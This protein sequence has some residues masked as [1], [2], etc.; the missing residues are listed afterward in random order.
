MVVF[1][2]A[3]INLGLSVTSRRPDGYHNLETLFYP[4]GWRDVLEIV[5][6]ADPLLKKGSCRFH[7]VGLDM[8]CAADDNLVVKA[9]RLLNSRY[10]LPA[11]DI[12]LWKVIPFKAGLGGG[13]SDAA[14][15]LTLLNELAGLN[16]PLDEL[17]E[18]AAQIGADCP[19]FIRN[20]PVMARGIG[21]EFSPVDV[22]LK[23]YHICIVKPQ[24]EVSTKEAYGGIVPCEPACSVADIVTNHPVGEWRGVLKNDF[25][26]PVFKL[27]PEIEQIKN[28]LYSHGA[29]YASMTGSGS[30]V[31]ALFTGAVDLRNHFADCDVWAES[32]NIRRA[33]RDSGN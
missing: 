13:S 2:N 8:E 31:F 15:A 20:R 29:V 6:S 22:S 23:N 7:S 19:F 5:P 17:E 12:H 16:R 24:A 26:T 33:R 14:F 18:L 30:A 1:P 25:E 4:V 28:D 3:K 32:N 9:Y 11:V 21:N 10:P 27:Y